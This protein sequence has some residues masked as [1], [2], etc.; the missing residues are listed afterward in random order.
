MKGARVAAIVGSVVPWLWPPAPARPSEP[1]RMVLVPGRARARPVALVTRGRETRW[2]LTVP[3][4]L[5]ASSAA[6]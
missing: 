3:P 5:V 6:S 1:E 2:R 4:G